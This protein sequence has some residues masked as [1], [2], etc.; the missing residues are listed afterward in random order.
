MKCLT[1]ALFA[2]LLMPLF[3]LA[4]S[5]YK[6]GYVVNLKGDTIHGF[7]DYQEWDSNPN[8]INFKTARDNKKS[9][10]FSPADIVYFNIGDVE[11]YQT[12]T[13]KISMDGTN[14]SNLSERDTSFKIQSVFL[15][16]LQKGTNL[17][18][19]SY[20]DN[21]KS[22]FYIGEAPNY[23]PV[24]LQYHVYA[25][26][27]AK[28]S[29][30]TITENTYMKQLFAL[31]NK[32]NAMDDELEKTF[33]D[34]NY[35]SWLILKIT[36]KINKTSKSE[37]KKNNK[38]NSGIKF[39]ANAGVNITNISPGISSPYADAGGKSSTSYGPTAGFGIAVLANPNTGKLQ[40]HA[41]VTVSSA[42]Y[43]SLYENKV[44]PYIGVK[45]S[46]NALIIALAPEVVYNF[47]NTDSFKFYGGVGFAIGYNNCSNAVFG[48]QNPADS[49][50][51]TETN[52]LYYFRKVE[53]S[54]VL[55]AGVQF[56]R[57]WGVFVDYISSSPL[58]NGGY[59]QLAV[60][61]ERVGINYLF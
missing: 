2:F 3:S 51:G 46:F 43:N 10:S 59:F 47:Y 19:F 18:L 52:N 27:N 37:Y 17:E 25:D 24:E 48:P 36:N 49:F 60:T 53:T 32:Y 38:V 13:G 40:L 35:S 15:K 11:T 61:Q 20:T 1:K 6:P 50:Y 58:T 45:A 8:S 12:Y 26:A 31:A 4:Q 56:S 54:F 28:N 21:I 29:S 7:I 34:E 42:S 57:K 55:K 39:F 33:Q 14:V 5:N 9:Q 16:I 22:R 41:E 23:I 30:G 44:S